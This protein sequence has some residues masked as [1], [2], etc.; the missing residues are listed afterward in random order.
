MWPL[1]PLRSFEGFPSD[2]TQGVAEVSALISLSLPSLA[3]NSH[4]NRKKLVRSFLTSNC[5]GSGQ[6]R[7]YASFRR[8]RPTACEYA[9]LECRLLDRDI[10][11]QCHIH[12]IRMHQGYR[13][14]SQQSLSETG[15][16]PPSWK[17]CWSLPLEAG[18]SGHER[19]EQKLGHPSH[20][21][22]RRC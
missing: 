15:P 14:W 18:V 11:S 8:N 6:R 1:T 22:T 16:S 3:R 4:K 9:H 12:R 7:S 2:P 21:T 10:P 20:L 13:R 17:R 5:R 19:S